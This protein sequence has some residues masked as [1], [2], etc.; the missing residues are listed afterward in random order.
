MFIRLKIKKKIKFF[1]LGPKNNWK[2]K[3]NKD[4]IKKM[5]TYYK[6]DLERFGY[7]I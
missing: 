6:E 1:Y 3:L 2:D 5:N 7:E 4:L